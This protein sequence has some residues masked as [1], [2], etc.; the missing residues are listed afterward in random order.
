LST[1]GRLPHP[2]SR[3]HIQCQASLVKLVLYAKKNYYTDPLT[4]IIYNVKQVSENSSFKK[5]SYTCPLTGLPHP[6]GRHHIHPVSGNSRQTVPLNKKY[7]TFPLTGGLPHPDV[8]HHIQI[9]VKLFHYKKK[10]LHSL[11]FTGGIRHP[12]G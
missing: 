11:F 9:F 8:R 2:N 1:R 12:L 6:N 7:Y 4:V 5:I 3:H 10:L